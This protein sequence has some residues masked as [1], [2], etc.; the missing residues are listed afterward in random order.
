MLN[1]LVLR[2]LLVL[3]FCEF[4]ELFLDDLPSVPPNRDINFGID[5][6]SDTNPISIPLNRI[7]LMS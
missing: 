1:I 6:L 4:P 5:I 7:A 3:V 2:V